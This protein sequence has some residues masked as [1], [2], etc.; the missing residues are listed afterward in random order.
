MRTSRTG[1][2]TGLVTNIDS[3]R[4]EVTD[5][6]RRVPMDEL[7]EEVTIFGDHLEVKVAGPPRINVTF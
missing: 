7:V 6:E 3:M 1:S 5:D 4:S 2:L